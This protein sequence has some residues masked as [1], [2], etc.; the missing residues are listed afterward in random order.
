MSEKDGGPAFPRDHAHDGHNGMTLRQ[1]AA[2]K[3]KVPESG[4]DWLDEMINKSLRNDLAAMAMPMLAEEFYSHN[5][6]LA[7]GTVPDLVAPVAYKFADAMLK[8]REQ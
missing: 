2:I 7:N 6:E 4:L 3:L 5:Q 1:Y 8:A